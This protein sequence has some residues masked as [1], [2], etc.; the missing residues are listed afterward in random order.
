[1]THRKGLEGLAVA[2][3]LLAAPGA[4]AQEAAHEDCSALRQPQRGEPGKDVLWEPTPDLAVTRMLTL[5]RVTAEDRVFD[6][7]SGD[8]RIPIVAARDFGATALGIEYNAALVAYAQ[9]QARAQ[10]VQA[11]A[12]FV[13][14]DVFASDFSS[15]TV[16]TTYLLPEMNLCLRARILAM[17]PGTRVAAHRFAMADWQP[18]VRE[19]VGEH[20]VF[21]WIVPARV[22][23]AWSLTDARGQTWR[24]ELTQS[25]QNVSGALV[26][27]GARRP[28]RDVRLRGAALSFSFTDAH[29]VSH[30]VTA[31]VR[32]ETLG[33]VVRSAEGEQRLVG[34]ALGAPRA[35]AWMTVPALCDRFFAPAASESRD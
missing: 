22:D 17:K 20:D 5:A 19:T 10:H 26:I 8:G 1:M 28:L 29:G 31:A 21:L 13:Q 9:C 15:A 18:D 23:G 27:A 11:R 30:D 34:R 6:L 3:L 25:F 2:A 24:V 32:E 35:G 12:T 33:G 16:L 14:G 7:G 4:R